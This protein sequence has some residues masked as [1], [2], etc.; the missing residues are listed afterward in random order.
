MPRRRFVPPTVGPAPPSIARPALRRDRSLRAGDAWAHERGGVPNRVRQSS[1]PD[2]L[3]PTNVQESEPRYGAD[4]SS[5][6]QRA[7]AAASS[8]RAISSVAE[9][10]VFPS[11]QANSN[12]APSVGGIRISAVHGWVHSS[13]SSYVTA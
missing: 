4:S 2:P 8:P 3:G 5:A 12:I 13:G 1:P 9:M 6:G 11:W 7:A 10:P